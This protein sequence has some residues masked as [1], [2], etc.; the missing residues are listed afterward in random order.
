MSVFAKSFAFDCVAECCNSG[1]K[2]RKI[3][4][5]GEFSIERL[6]ACQLIFIETPFLLS[7][8]CCHSNITLTS[9]FYEFKLKDFDIF[10][11]IEFRGG[12]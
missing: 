2:R 11:S 4:R 6:A 9:R 7:R 10:F 1:Y 3:P 8:R 5:L 12:R